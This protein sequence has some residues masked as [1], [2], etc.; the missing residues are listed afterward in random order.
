MTVI[1][2][3][4]LSVCILGGTLFAQQAKILDGNGLLPKCEAAVQVQNSE[5]KEANPTESAYCL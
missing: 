2:W 4:V 1:R 5:L 3:G